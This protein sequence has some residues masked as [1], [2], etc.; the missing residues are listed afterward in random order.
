MAERRGSAGVVVTSAEEPP[1]MVVMRPA[2]LTRRIRRLEVSAMMTLP[3][4]SLVIAEALVMLAATA[5]PPSP[6]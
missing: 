1:A 3:E 5:G 6:E 4:A 2:A